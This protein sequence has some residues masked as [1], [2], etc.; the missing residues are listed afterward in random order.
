ME[1]GS[2]S[3]PARAPPLLSW[4][5]LELLGWSSEEMEAPWHLRS[6]GAEQ[7]SE[8]WLAGRVE[9]TAVISHLCITACIF[10]SCR[11]L[12][13]WLECHLFHKASLIQLIPTSPRLPGAP[14]HTPQLAVTADHFILQ[15]LRAEPRT[16][17]CLPGRHGAPPPPWE[18]AFAENVQRV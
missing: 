9:M 8:A 12:R 2:E 16:V 4:A 18:R 11:P 6:E 7:L 10:E 1:E 14:S 5:G 3:G 17:I 13:P 15:T